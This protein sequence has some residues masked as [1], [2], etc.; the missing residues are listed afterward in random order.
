MPFVPDEQ[1]SVASDAPPKQGG[2]LERIGK[3]VLNT[4]LRTMGLPTTAIVKPGMRAL[5]ASS[6]IFGGALKASREKL[7]GEYAAPETGI[8]VPFSRAGGR[9]GLDVGE[10]ILPTIV[11]SYRGLRDR[12]T[13]MEEAPKTLGLDPDS[14]AGMATGLAAEVAAPDP[15]DILAF[16]RVG[17]R[18]ME[19]AGQALEK[20]GEYLVES[21]VRP[22]KTQREGFQKAYKTT[23][24]KFIA[25][26]GLAGDL[27]EN[28]TDRIESLQDSFDRIA[29]ESGRKILTEDVAT[30]IRTYANRLDKT[31]EKKEINAL[32]EFADA[33]VERGSTIGAEELTE[34]R[35]LLDKRI[36][37]S[38][39]MRL[40]AGDS[41][42]ADVQKRF[43]LS[44]AI[45]QYLGDIKTA[46]GKTLAELGKELSPLYR[47][48]EIAGL[49]D[50][51]TVAGRLG[52][53]G[54]I[55]AL[56]GGFAA[57]GAP[58]SL[59]GFITRR[60]ASN[61]TVQGRAGKAA[62]DLSGAV[63]SPGLINA[64]GRVGLTAGKEALLAPY[65]GGDK[66]Q[67][68]EQRPSAITGATPG[69]IPD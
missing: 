35:R 60:L 17:S 4:G 3:G 56:A 67:P 52:G 51:V 7:S 63:S 43:A 53:L 64:L 38:Q 27:A 61:Q 1:P 32:N 48:D 59:L 13:L 42:N 8:T 40:F 24:G 39:W 33:I 58:G 2:I 45:T 36:P 54:D 66:N 19:G 6:N 11:G 41:V 46:D 16:G 44:D 25:D 30:M 29:I 68:E 57:A 21:G 31:V 65:Y 23:I 28:L 22:T 14:V 12:N 15:A 20:T 9:E 26:K 49:Q 18:A 62:L 69:F 37:K 50:G 34:M 47:L 55:S 5:E 10:L